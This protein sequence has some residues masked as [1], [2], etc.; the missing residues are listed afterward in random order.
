[1]RSATPAASW[2]ERCLAADWR[3]HRAFRHHAARGARSPR[4]ADA[5]DAVGVHHRA[6]RGAKPPGLPRKRRL[7]PGDRARGLRLDRRHGSDRPRRGRARRRAAVARL[8]RPAQR[9]TGPRERRL[10]ARDRRRRAREP[11]AARR[12]RALSRRSAQTASSLGGLPLRE[13]FLG[14][15][16]GPS[17]KYPKYRHRLLRRGAY[18]H[19][20]ARTVHEGFIPDGR[21]AAARRRPHPPARDELER[22]ARRRVALRPPRGRSAAGS[23]LAGRV[24]ARRARAARG[25]A[26]LSTG[27]RRRLA[28]RVA[29][30]RQDLARLRHRHG[31]LDAPSAGPS[32]RERGRSGVAGERA[33]RL[34]QA[35]S[36]MRSGWWALPADRS[37]RR[38]SPR[39]AGQRSGRRRRRRADRSLRRRLEQSA[40][41]VRVAA[42]ASGRSR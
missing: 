3:R 4:P 32:R 20:E 11:A 28:G 34:A 8:C 33:L 40:V 25:Q 18:R 35:P 7:L 37:A 5:G 22:G 29:G 14:R 19:D 9:R 6:R 24:A 12:D 15:A 23:A 10:G 13:I 41:R 39:L 17:A 31:R 1:M 27:D 16:L 21:R 42:P 30:P 26:A 36:W 38:R 2:A